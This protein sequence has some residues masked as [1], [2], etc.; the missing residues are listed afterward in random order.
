MVVPPFS[1]LFAGS[2][3]NVVAFLQLLGDLRPIVE[4]VLGNKFGD[5][6]VFLI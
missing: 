1:A 5:G 6:F 3:G 4:S 2:F